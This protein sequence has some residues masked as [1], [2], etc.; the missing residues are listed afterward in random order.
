MTTLEGHYFDGARPVAVPARLDFDDRKVKL[1]AERVADSVTEEFT[2]DQLNISP[3]IG[4][5]ERFIDLPNGGQFLCADHAFL[6]RLPQESPSE[7]LVAWLEQRWRVALGCVVV[8]FAMLLS[9]YVFGLPAA[10]RYLSA[11]I[12]FRTEAALGAEAISWL[13]DNGWLNPTHLASDKQKEIDQGFEGLFRG[14]PFEEHY[15]LH[16]RSSRFM[17]PNAFALPGGSIVITDKMIETAATTEEVMAVLAHEIAHVEQRHTLRNIMQSSAIGLIAATVTADAA[18]LSGAVAGLPAM[19]AQTKYSR[20]F[21][22]EADDYAFKLLKQ[23]GYSPNAFA[24]LMERLSKE[25][26]QRSGPMTWISTHPATSRRVE[27][28]RAAARE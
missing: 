9:G 20:R 2:A 3:R 13:D 18:T 11:R 8:I 5:S 14:L 19:L 6:D 26:P 17:G 10:A 4:A 23:K 25:H 28:A 12:P 27:K 7:G 16:F 24:D 21:E 22:A 15:H 1:T